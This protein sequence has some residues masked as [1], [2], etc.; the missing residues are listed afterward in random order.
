MTECRNLRTIKCIIVAHSNHFSFHPIAAVMIYMTS[1][2]SIKLVVTIKLHTKP[3][4]AP[5]I[6][7]SGG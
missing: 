5:T 3:E 1:L 7:G 4:A 6:K 2:L